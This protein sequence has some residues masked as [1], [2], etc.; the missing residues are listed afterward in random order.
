M[1]ARPTL[2]LKPTE[3]VARFL[4]SEK[5]GL[6]LGFGAGFLLVRLGDLDAK[7]AAVVEAALEGAST[8]DGPDSERLLGF[9]TMIAPHALAFSAAR[10]ARGSFGVAELARMIGRTSHFAV[11]LRKRPG[12]SNVF[13]ER[14]SVGRSRTNDIVLR[15]DSVS[16][17]QAW[18]ERDEDDH[19]FACGAKS[20][21]PTTVNGVPLLPLART[22]L[23]SGDEICFGDVPS[24]F[25]SA[26]L[27]R[28]ALY[29]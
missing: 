21:N 2:P 24:V 18:L 3:L 6:E 26:P 19:V 27:L 1:G 14:I 20:T 17:F 5:P 25:C 15:H 28:E 8:L 22:T 11:A 29:R 7:Q 23:A 12:A 4:A 9:D 10:K 13:A 16:K